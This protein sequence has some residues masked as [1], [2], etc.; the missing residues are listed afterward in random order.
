MKIAIF[1]TVGAGKTTLIDKLKSK[2]PKD[3]QVFWEPLSDN[4]YFEDSYSP[5]QI[6]SRAA[7]YKMEL[8]ML[9]NRMKQFLDSKQ[10]QNVIYDRGI[11]DTIIFAHCNYEA[12]NIDE[13]DWKV[14]REYFEISVLPSIFKGPNQEGYDLVVYLKVSPETS[15]RRIHT[16][17][18]ERELAVDNVFWTKLTEMYD[19]WYL[20]LK[21]AFP[22][23]VIDG[24]LE[25]PEIYANQV[26]AHVKQINSLGNK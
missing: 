5:N 14:Y 18:I 12:G 25:D 15:I 9:A 24:N 26:I 11:M 17:A 20:H 22:F 4:P 8:L 16:R 23:M 6:I 3:Y 10:Y 19:R 1:G 7:A 21:D 13:R 2:L